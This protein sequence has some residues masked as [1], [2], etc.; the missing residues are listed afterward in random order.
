MRT[1]S[2][3]SV[4]FWVYEQRAK[5]GEAPVY[6]RISI[7]N[8][9]LNIS[10]KRKVILSLWDSRAQRLT[11]TDAFSLELNEF[12]DQEYSRL[13]QCY[14]ELRIE[15]K[16][17][18]VENIKKKYF[19]EEGKL[20]S[21][22][23]I[24]EY[25]NTTCFSKLSPNTSRLYITSQNYVRRFIKKEYNRTDYY[26][27]ELDYSFV[28]RFDNFLRLTKSNTH[29]RNLQHNAVM[30]HI[31]RLKKMVS[32]AHRLEWINKNP[33]LNFK[34]TLEPRERTFLS[35]ENFKKIEK[36]DLKSNRLSRVR[37]LFIFSCYT[38]ISYGDLVLLKSDNLT[39]G[40]NGKLWI[41]TRRMK[42]GNSV[43]VPL[44]KKAITIL[45]KYKNDIACEITQTL[46]PKISNQKVNQYLKEIAELCEISQDVTF[47][48][49]RHTFATTVALSNGMPIETVSKILG[50]KKLST[51]Q[52][53]AKV[54][55]RKLG[56]DMD[57]LELK[58][59]RVEAKN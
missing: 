47:H 48:L 28:I 55:E 23:D 59:E 56:D 20:Y 41:V 22:E 25:H 17:R 34:S 8:K 50:H 11:G 36:I 24:F 33:F 10:L 57:Y 3:F 54:V 31:Q 13:F 1:T 32:L 37:D 2:T 12:L 14:Q 7:D 43:K 38:G 45:D 15:G 19:G 46:L 27:Q 5:N 9:K 39:I 4:L 52:I 21:L 30:K 42:N 51:T 58:I 35:A 6:A 44:L 26:L 29:K 18:T 16:L 49:A 40:V 53:Y